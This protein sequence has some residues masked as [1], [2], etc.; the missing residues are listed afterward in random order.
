MKREQK[1]TLKK[2][3]WELFDREEI[4]GDSSVKK[5]IFDIIRDTYREIGG[6]PDF[7]DAKSV[8][9]DNTEIDLID[10]DADPD[11]D[12]VVMGKETK[13]GTKLTAMGT[14]GGKEAK[15]KMVN[16]VAKLLKTR[17]NYG[18][19]SGKIANILVSKGSPVVSGQ[20]RVKEILT[21]KNI[22][23]HGRHPDARTGY[24]GWYNRLI[25]GHPHEKIMVG[26]PKVFGEAQTIH[27]EN[28]PIKQRMGFLEFLEATDG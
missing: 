17:G 13:Y 1:I 5:S 21:G 9:S 18:E 28:T 24:T 26:K 20:E 15:S 10:T 8:P 2:N 4:Q 11:P 25:G 19:V 7:P 22:Q 6:H 16:F 3:T 12:A 27:N 23:W 14:D